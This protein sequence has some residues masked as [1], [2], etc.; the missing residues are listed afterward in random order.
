[1][2]PL[3]EE[4]S[5]ARRRGDERVLHHVGR[6]KAPAQP[7]IEPERND[8]LKALLMPRE[9]H[10]PRI[11]ISAS[12][13]VQQQSGVRCICGFHWLPRSELRATA[14]ARH[15]LLDMLMEMHSST[16]SIGIEQ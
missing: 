15:E 9:K 12:G 13:A 2:R 3:P 1:M 14:L 5:A 11:D 7:R 10:A 4:L 6:I 8:R 16:S